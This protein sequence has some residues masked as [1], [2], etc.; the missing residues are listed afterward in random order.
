MAGPTSRSPYHGSSSRTRRSSA[1]T[2]GA[3][4]RPNNHTNLSNPNSNNTNPSILSNLPGIDTT[5]G[6]HLYDGITST[7][8]RESLDFNFDLDVPPNLHRNNSTSHPYQNHFDLEHF[9][10]SRLSFGSTATNQQFGSA[11]NFMSLNGSGSSSFDLSSPIDTTGKFTRR[12]RGGIGGSASRILHRNR[13]TSAGYGGVL[14]NAIPNANTDVKI[15]S[16][17]CKNGRD[18]NGSS[19]TTREIEH[20]PERSSFNMRSDE[21]NQ[22]EPK[23]QE[24]KSVMV[25]NLRSIINSSLYSSKHTVNP[26]TAAFYA[27]I[28]Y[29]KTSL[30]SD[31][32]L[33]A[34]ALC[35]NNEKRRAVTILDRAGVLSFETLTIEEKIFSFPKKNEN[36]DTEEKDSHEE[37]N[38]EGV[39]ALYDEKNYLLCIMESMLLACDCYGSAGEWEEVMNIL[40]DACRCEYIHSSQFY[41]NIIEEN[42]DDY[43]P[44]WQIS[45]EEERN[46]LLLAKYLNWTGSEGGINP[47]ARLASMRGRACDEASNPNRAASFLKLALFIDIKCVDSW[48]YL[49]QR[50]LLSSREEMEMVTSLKFDDSMNWL[51]DIFYARL[52]F[53]PYGVED[54]GNL[55]SSKKGSILFRESIGS[56]IVPNKIPHFQ[57]TP[58]M[59]IDASA[60]QFQ[61]TPGTSFQLGV[62][63]D[64]KVLSE[65]KKEVRGP[66]NKKN[67]ILKQ[68]KQSFQNLHVAH[69]LSNCSDVLGLAATR[70]FNNYN[71]KLALHYCQ[72]LYE[73]DPLCTSAAGIQI[74][75]L[76]ALGHK[77]P[78][79]RLAHAL[80]DADAKSG[81][82][83]YA[84]GCYYYACGRYDL[85][86]QYFWRATR[87]DPRNADCWIAF[88]CAFAACDEN[89]QANACFRSAQRLHSGSHYPML[90]MGMEHLRTNNVP[91]AGHYLKSARSIEL[92]DPLCSNELGVWAY[93]RKDWNEAIKWFTMALRLYINADVAEADAFTW[94]G[95]NPLGTDGRTPN[96][97]LF[98][99]GNNEAKEKVKY[100]SDSDCIEF[101]QEAFWEPTLFNLGQSYRKNLQYQEAIHCFEKCIS[102]C[103]NNSMPFAALGFTHHIIGDLDT[104]IEAYHQSLSRKSNDTFAQEMLEKALEDSIDTVDYFRVGDHRDGFTSGLHS[105]LISS[106]VAIDRST[107]GTIQDA[108]NSNVSFDDTNS[109]ID[110]S[111]T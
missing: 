108:D 76:T 14:V 89:D 91:L 6:N 34:Q 30:P 90:Y 88:G 17:N 85:A 5:V 7:T 13:I 81:I 106:Q 22:N 73:R 63:S 44:S 86:Q 98:E 84:V 28:L 49:C 75:T 29:A 32:F 23:A 3:S 31:A 66:M 33:Y 65:F 77:R 36:G 104:A 16:Q 68:V 18:G 103:P 37:V 35:A 25:S 53:S 15:R 59:N 72:I 99:F 9:T 61:P 1:G 110:M 79:F 52:S 19:N 41:C 26:S 56:P 97:P 111:M 60:I 42:N 51:K 82:S 71:L 78:L 50:R 62:L 47:V 101:C 80:V 100:L 21:I 40:D 58:H 11:S 102:L 45:T 95:D 87:L 2:S 94:H 24:F 20:S 107:M 46:L 92:S 64:P 55:F 109:D 57:P 69:G 4:R 39:V 96:L 83:W 38:D 93:R 48:I 43:L 27:S 8:S 10:S 74:A 67:D 54:D 105:P 70:A 12:E